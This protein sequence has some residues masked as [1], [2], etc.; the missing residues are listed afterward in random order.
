MNNMD[1]MGAGMTL[2]M[3]LMCLLIIGV[4]VLSVAALWK[5]L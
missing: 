1:M 3:G 2:G 4:L 5:Y